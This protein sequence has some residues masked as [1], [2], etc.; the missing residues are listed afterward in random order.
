MRAAVQRQ[1]GGHDLLTIDEVESLEIGADGVLVKVKAAAV[2]PGD[3]AMLTGVPYVNRLAVSG[4]RRP[5]FPVPG[6]DVAGVVEAVG[7]GVATLRVGDRVFGN[8]PGSLAEF[9]ATTEDQLAP[10]PSGWSFEEAAGVTESGCVA[11]QAVDDQAEIAAGQEVAVI[12]AGG[13]VGCFALQLAK[14]RGAAVTAVCGTRMV[15]DVDALGVD[16]VV[17]YTRSDLTQTGVAYNVII[18]TAGKTP[19]SDLRQALASDGRLIIVGADHSRRIT[20]GL[21]RWLRA[22]LW[23][24]LVSQRL[25]PFA[26]SKLSADHLHELAELMESGALRPVIDRVFAFEDTADALNY[27]DRRD[28]PGKVIVTVDGG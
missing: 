28:R 20:G 17:D 23:S 22:L 7:D 9:A 27:L 16:R 1:Y 8:A 21:G 26:A 12:G 14:A 18:D 25:R 3:R 11:L 19:L 24:P 4:L 15:E 2:S 10:I 5:K 6:Y 13:G